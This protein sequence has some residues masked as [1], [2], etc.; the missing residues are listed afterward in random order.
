M[1]PAQA[2]KLVALKL[3]IG[4]A[5]G[6]TVNVLTVL[7]QLFDKSRV[8]VTEVVPPGADTEYVEVVAVGTLHVGFT[9]PVT[10]EFVT[11]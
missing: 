10:V 8:Y 3:T 5:K 1:F 2:V 9:V 6:Y 11:E 4:A 7:P